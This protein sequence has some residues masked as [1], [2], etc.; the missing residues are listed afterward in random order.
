MITFDVQGHI[1]IN[2]VVQSFLCYSGH[3][4]GLNN[5]AMENDKGVGRL[6]RGMYTISQFF[7]HPHFGPCVARLTQTSGDTFGRAG[8]MIHGDNPRMDHSASDGCIVC[9]RT[10]REAIRA[11][12]ERQLEVE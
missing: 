11:S 1:T 10:V 2:G 5:P 9:P 7:D 4:E 12:G 8:F 3:A 6:P